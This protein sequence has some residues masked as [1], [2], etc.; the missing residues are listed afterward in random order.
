MTWMNLCSRLWGQNWRKHRWRGHAGY[1][2]NSP[3]PSALI[4]PFII[5]IFHFL[6]HVW[7]LHQSDASAQTLQ[8]TFSDHLSEFLHLWGHLF[9]MK[10]SPLMHGS[11]LRLTVSVSTGK[12]EQHAHGWCVLFS[13]FVQHFL[14]RHFSDFHHDSVSHYCS[15]GCF[16][17][18]SWVRVIFLTCSLRGVF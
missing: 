13:V 16:L 10:H 17:K 15:F 8:K 4:N 11:D 7:A 5:H 1:S 6:L 2:F 12:S 9:S 18:N 3:Q 14:S